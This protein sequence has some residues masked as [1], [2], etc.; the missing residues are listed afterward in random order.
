MDLQKA[1]V[2]QRATRSMLKQL[3]EQ[4]DYFQRKRQTF[5]A[6]FME[7]G[8]QNQQFWYRTDAFGRVQ[9]QNDAAFVVEQLFVLPSESAFEGSTEWKLS[10]TDLSAGRE[11]TQIN[12]RV[13]DV[14]S[15]ALP[16]QPL[17]PVLDSGNTHDDG[18]YWFY[19]VEQYLLPRSSV[20]EF[21]VSNGSTLGDDDILLSNLVLGGHKV[22]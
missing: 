19:L 7:K 20:L 5:Y 1:K 9:L 17:A 16:V 10:I 21:R 8:S 14:D 3:E 6:E 4:F 2:V 22:F 18:D 15:E 11:L 13:P 12:A